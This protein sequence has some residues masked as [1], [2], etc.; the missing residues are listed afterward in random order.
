MFV[1]IKPSFLC[2]KMCHLLD[3]ELLAGP[4]HRLL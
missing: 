3:A 1:T 2:V 4:L